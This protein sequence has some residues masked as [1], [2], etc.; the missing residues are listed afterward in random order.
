MR[1]G[2]R[3]ACEGEGRCEGIRLPTMV[4]RLGGLAWV[5]HF[6]V[7]STLMRSHVR[8]AFVGL[9][10]DAV[11]FAVIRSAVIGAAEGIY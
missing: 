1:S 10:G 11:D 6:G 7:D 4:A 5:K 2:L 3:I 8:C 9:L